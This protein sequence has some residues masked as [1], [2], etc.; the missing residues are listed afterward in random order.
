M[1]FLAYDTSDSEPP[2][3]QK[4]VKVVYERELPCRSKASGLAEPPS[5]LRFPVRLVEGSAEGPSEV[6]APRHRL[7][8]SS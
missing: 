1:S 7:P 5:Q 4:L 6:G 3:H 2:V 8:E